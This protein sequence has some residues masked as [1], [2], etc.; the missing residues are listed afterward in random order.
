MDWVPTLL[1]QGTLKALPKATADDF[2]AL[3]HTL[4]NLALNK[5]VSTPSFADV[6]LLNPKFN[7]ETHPELDTFLFCGEVL[8]KTTAEKLLARFPQAKIFNTYGPTEATVA[9][10]GL[11]ITPEIMAEYD[12]MPIGYA[13]ADTDIIIQDL[14]GA[15]LPDGETGEIVIAGPSVSKGYLNIQKRRRLPLQPLMAS[16][17]ITRV[18]WQRVMLM[19]CCIIVVEQTSKSNY[20]VSGLN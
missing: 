19:A 8:T 7:Q 18:I 1:S 12:K 16:K 11:Q 6:A 4:P 3:F 9:V 13:N 5:W 2:K 10:T 15:V 20:T 17:L 14:D